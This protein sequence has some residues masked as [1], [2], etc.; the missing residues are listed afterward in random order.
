LNCPILYGISRKSF[1]FKTFGL[2]NRDEITKIYAQHLISK[3]TNI[4]RVHDVKGHSDLIK[5]LEKI[6]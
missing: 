2:E 4:L 3:G 1:I 6:Q 5:Y